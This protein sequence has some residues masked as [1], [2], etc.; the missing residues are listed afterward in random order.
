M[1]ATSYV[2]PNIK[3]N[4]SNIPTIL[5][6]IIT[7]FLYVFGIFSFYEYIISAQGQK[8]LDQLTNN[9]STITNIGVNILPYILAFLFFY[10]VISIV[11]SYIL[12]KIISKVGERIMILA[13]LVGPIFLILLGFLTIIIGIGIIFL[14]FGFIMLFIVIYRFRA[15]KR[16]GKFIE[17]SASLALDEKALLMIPI[18]MGL[19]TLI[20]GFFMMA[21]Y[22]E[23]NQIV[24]NYL[25]SSSPDTAN[26]IGT[27]L[28]LLFEYFYLVI[29]LG[30]SYIFNA[31][32]ISYAGDWYRGLDPDLRS[33]R[34]DVRD[35]LPII[36]KFAFA[37]AT[38]QMIFRI[39]NRMITSEVNTNQSSGNLTGKRGS[40]S[41]GNDLSPLL[42]LA[43]IGY[44]FTFILGAIWQFLNYFTLISIIQKKKGLKE[45]IKDS[46][47]TMW[48]G[49]IDIYLADTGYGTTMFVF[50][51]LNA[52]I[53]F[54]VGFGVG[55]FSLGHDYMIAFVVGVL[56]II[57][58]LLPYSIVTIPLN[59]SFKTFLYCFGDDFRD[60][61]QKPSRL[62]NELRDDLNG[63]QN[64]WGKRKMNNPTQ[65][66]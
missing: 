30:L 20:S 16:A 43:F 53:W 45:S 46:A 38:I 49:Y 59:T 48:D 54:G 44:I 55:Y 36:L 24:V 25:S 28:S 6:V 41:S 5:F 10:L 42:V 47:K 39:F 32:I 29:Y 35:V 13:T 12:L 50:A 57:L 52:L 65:I 8:F 60:G 7:I 37:M 33:A 15:V 31:L 21:S 19:F 64:N 3:T 26:S 40:G 22:W 56:F 14:I 61:F 66:Y 51:V 27:V 2:K 4:F 62:P 11:F 58:S 1:S 18:V 17:F 23:V 63:L 9:S 34:R